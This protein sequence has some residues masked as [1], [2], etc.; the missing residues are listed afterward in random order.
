MTCRVGIRTS[1]G[2]TIQ[3]HALLD[4]LSSTS[5]NSEHLARQLHL[6]Q[7]QQFVEVDD[8]GGTTDKSSRLVVQ[9]IVHPSNFD[10]KERSSRSCSVAQGDFELASPHCI[11]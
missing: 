9:F 7:K 8:I 6:S 2:N 3:A 10:R 5:F 11:V 4:R 1:Y